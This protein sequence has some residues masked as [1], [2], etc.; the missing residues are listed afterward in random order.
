M[1]RILKLTVVSLLLVSFLI[2]YT[3]FAETNDDDAEWQELGISEEEFY[4]ILAN[5]MDNSVSAYSSDLIAGY[6]L[7]C[8]NQNG[9]LAVAGITRGKTGVIRCGIIDITIQ[10]RKSGSSSWSYYTTLDDVYR[11]TSVCNLY[12]A[13]V[14]P[15][16]YEYRA[17][18]TH[19]AKKNILSTQTI[20]NTS[21]VIAF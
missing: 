9:R 7:S 17:I 14:V 11:D 15:G 20:K 2:P 6:I 19:Y 12:E 18:C 4:S 21:N 3:A 1:K 10:R 13:F 8:G 5:N 16:K